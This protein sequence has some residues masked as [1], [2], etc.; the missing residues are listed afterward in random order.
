[1]FAFLVI[2]AKPPAGVFTPVEAKEPVVLL[3]QMLGE[4][5]Q[6]TIVSNLVYPMK[7]G[8]SLWTEAEQ[9]AT[10]VHLTETLNES[11][12]GKVIKPTV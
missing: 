6:A 11:E 7:K 4:I 12:L 3:A 8:M 10:F 5:E 9:S 2:V 1:M